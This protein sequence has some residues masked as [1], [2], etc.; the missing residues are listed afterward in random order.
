MAKKRKKIKSGSE[1]PEARIE[2]GETGGH[3]KDNFAGEDKIEREKRMFMRV[4]IGCIMGVF[5]I[6]WI[7]NLKYQF[8]ASADKSD[9][10]GFSL[11][12]A[13]TELEQVMSRVKQGI[14][15]IKQLQKT[16]QNN[17]PKEPELT[18]QQIDLLKGKLI[19]EA[20]TG[21]ATSTKKN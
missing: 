8:A 6:I 21:T 9:K 14:A 17:L 20:A 10:T 2:S 3:K 12:Q 13:G 5:F 18:S 11:G 1:K 19:N 15:E 16:A 4:A 7:V